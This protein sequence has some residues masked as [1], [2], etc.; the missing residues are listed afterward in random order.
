NNELK[1]EVCT[2]KTFITCIL[3]MTVSIASAQDTDT[4][5]IPKLEI[6]RNKKEVFAGR[7]SSLVVYIDTLVMK[8]KSQLVFF[9]KKDVQLHVQHATI[10]KRGYIYGTDGKNN[11]TDFTID[12]GF[13]KLGALYVLAGGQDAN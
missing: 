13:E 3:I 6:E 5:H 10:E 4:I 1:A 8:N 12:M 2:M 11:G 7:D 9:G